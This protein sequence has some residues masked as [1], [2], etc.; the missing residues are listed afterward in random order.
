MPS[1]FASGSLAMCLKIIHKSQK[2]K[3]HIVVASTGG[4]KTVCEF[5][6]G[7]ADGFFCTRPKW[8][9]ACEAELRRMPFVVL[10]SYDAR[11]Y[12]REIPG[13]NGSKTW[14]SHRYVFRKVDQAGLI[15]VFVYYWHPEPAVTHKDHST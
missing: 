1:G 5:R 12:Y 15:H 8:D 4:E 7:P 6:R 3:Y 11:V 13:E 10:D 9:R 2:V 14:K